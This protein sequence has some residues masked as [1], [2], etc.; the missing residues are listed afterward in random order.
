MPNDQ[1][2]FCFVNMFGRVG[3]KVYSR[4]LGLV[5]ESRLG[6]SNHTLF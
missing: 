5:K 1:F 4:G 3:N 6:Y 2:L